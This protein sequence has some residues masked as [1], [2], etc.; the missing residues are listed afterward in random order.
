MSGSVVSPPSCAWVFC[1]TH[2]RFD[3]ILPASHLAPSRGL[4]RT[5]DESPSLLAC[6][7]GPVVSE[8]VRCHHDNVMIGSFSARL[9]FKLAQLLWPHVSAVPIPLNPTYNRDGL[10]TEHGSDFLEDELFRRSYAAGKA[11]GS[12]W[13]HDLEWRAYVVC[14]AAWRGRSLPGDF[15]ECGVH[16]GGY[17]RMIAEYVGLDQ[18]PQKKLRMFDTFSGIPERYLDARSAQAFAG[19]YGDCYAEVVQ[20]FA[21]YEN[22]IV[23]RGVV[24]DVL[25]AA[26][27]EGVCFLSIDLN[28]VEPS[29]AA[30]EYFW[31]RMARG[32]AMVLDDYNF[33]FFADQKAAFDVF[34]EEIGVEI[35]SLPTGQGI[36]IKP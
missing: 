31:P 16:R 14:W 25:P 18:L 36:L 7:V 1:E 35:L 32:A 5:H 11:T 20:T 33:R 30:A 3:R 4:P 12:W 10:L 21:R 26:H 8:R 27:V 28:C 15:V 29:I 9:R 2:R 22:A 24:P 34:A 19:V 17:S 6:C 23:V 13:H